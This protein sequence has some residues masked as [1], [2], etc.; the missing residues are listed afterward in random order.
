MVMIKWIFCRRDLMWCSVDTVHWSYRRALWRL[1]SL[2]LWCTTVSTHSTR[3][4]SISR[5]TMRPSHVSP[6]TTS[7][8]TL[9]ST[10]PPVSNQ[11]HR[12][13]FIRLEAR[14]QPNIGFTLRRVLAITPPNVNRFGWNLEHSWVHCRGLALADFG[15]DPRST[16]CWR[17]RR[18]FVFFQMSKQRT[19]SPIFRRQM[20]TKFEHNT[21]IGV[22]MKTFGT[23]LWKSDRTGLFFQKKTQTVLENF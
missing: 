2:I 13:I 3:G 22:A 21:S 10:S 16:D 1:S 17:A 6:S 9:S 4:R 15:R 8:N 18:N 7:L 12:P 19:I 23:E 11:S 14:L 5:S 20:F